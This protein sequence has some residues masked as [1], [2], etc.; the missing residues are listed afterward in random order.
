MVKDEFMPAIEKN[1]MK[2]S[3]KLSFYTFR[4]NTKV[5][6]FVYT[7]STCGGHLEWVT[8]QLLITNCGSGETNLEKER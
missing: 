1:T 4:Y 2:T 3:Q 6:R 7:G 5:M 8:A